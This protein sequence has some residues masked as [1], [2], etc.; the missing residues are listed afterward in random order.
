MLFGI[1]LSK[2]NIILKNCFI[3][4]ICRLLQG[5]CDN[6]IMTTLFLNLES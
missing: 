1:N 5:Y 2:R 6:E 3:Y 4:M